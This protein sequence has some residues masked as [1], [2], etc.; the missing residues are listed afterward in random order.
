M[1][2]RI[3]Q[4]FWIAILLVGMNRAGAFALLGPN[5]EDF[6][7]EA[8]G[9]NPNALDG[10]PIAPKNI[11]E[12]Y[13]RNKPVLYY[14]FDQNFLDFFGSNGVAAV[15]AAF[16]VFNGLA[17]TNISSYNLQD[18][19][20]EA[21][22][23]NY[24]AQALGLTDVKSMIMTLIIEQLGLTHP[25]RYVWAL[26][27]RDHVGAAPCPAGMRYVVIKRNFDP[28]L[29]GP[30][31]LLPSSYVNG[32]LYTYRIV[33]FCQTPVPIPDI[34]ADAVEYPVDPLAN[35][36]T[37][38]AAGGAAPILY[39]GAVYTANSGLLEGGY[40]TG[41]TRDDVGGLKY[42]MRTNNMNIE[43]AGQDTISFVT[44]NTPQI[45]FTSNLTV[46]A[47]A[48]LTNSPAQLVALFPGLQIGTSTSYFTNVVSLQTI[49]YFTN[50]PFD[51]AGTPP[52][53]VSAEVATTN[54]VLYYQHEFLNVLTN[55]Y[56]TTG[57]VTYLITNVSATAC[58]PFSPPGLVC[59]NVTLTTQIENGVFGDY[60]F[61]PTNACGYS[62]IQTQLS[63]V[64]T[65]TNE[66]LVA[67]NAPGTTNAA[68]EFYSSTTLYSYT[69][70]VLQ[71]RLVECPTD[72]VALRQGIERVRFE[73]RDYD[74]LLNQFF[75]PVTN[76]YVLYSI[77][78]STVIAQPTRRDVFFPDILITAY[79][80]APDPGFVG[81]PAVAR[82]VNFSSSNLLANLAGP[83]TI[84]N[85]TAFALNKIGPSFF[86]STGF[87]GEDTQTPYFIWG[88]FDGSTNVPVIY[89]NGT[90]IVNLENQVL[91]QINPGGP[92]LPD[93]IVGSPYQNG[94]SGFAVNGGTPP[95]NWVLSPDSSPLPPG[96]AMSPTTGMISGIPT[97]AGTYNFSIR[98]SDAGT[99]FVD[100]LYSIKIN[101]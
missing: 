67:T 82:S 15:D 50:Y 101:P 88:S 78:N 72:F 55:T 33:E 53:L 12:E 14:S 91:I 51:P 54:V 18:F 65:I 66:T 68:N 83:G 25:D 45:L 77:T 97:T 49:Y 93:G 5:N 23:I 21:S 70:Y 1:L 84:I 71:V 81:V 35:T 100:R 60:V 79:D 74:S 4:I 22:R 20:M 40:Y 90:S 44:N 76:N 43:A 61:L 24:R 13:R 34:L 31:Q 3:K 99:I 8:N 86:N 30:D 94:F 11:G 56:A 48:A 39:G 27:A 9:Y 46:L 42:L 17:A 41:L 36:F 10:V 64:V 73:R 96:L 98:L 92:D 59:S 6:Q 85:S 75:Y 26:H 52:R 37:A 16:E 2:P 87:W 63:Q 95:Y 58:P 38:V 69:Q 7:I 47:N 29:G 62:L 32:T 89:P 80:L 57:P 19:P 28:V